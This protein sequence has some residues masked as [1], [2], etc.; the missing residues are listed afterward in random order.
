MNIFE[1]ESDEDLQTMKVETQEQIDELRNELTS[2]EDFIDDVKF[3]QD[4]R[5]VKRLAYE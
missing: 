1:N 2:C 3:E 4:R 5:E